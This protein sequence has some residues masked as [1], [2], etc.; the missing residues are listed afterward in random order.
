MKQMRFHGGSRR[1]KC[2][3]RHRKIICM[4]QM[5]LL[6]THIFTI[7]SKIS[8]ARRFS[9]FGYFCSTIV[10]WEIS[11]VIHTCPGVVMNTM[12]VSSPTTSSTF[13]LSFSCGMTKTGLNSLLQ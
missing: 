4:T 7:H 3:D 2:Q 12:L 5:V 8:P 1:M 9:K 10:S 6:P 11:K 13:S